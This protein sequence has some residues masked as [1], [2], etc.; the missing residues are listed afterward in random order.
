MYAYDGD[1]LGATYQAG[2]AELKLWAPTATDVTANV[3]G[4][5]DATQFIG[6]VAL[7]KG[8][9]GV[10]SVQLNPGDLG[11]QDFRGYFYQYEV[12]NNGVTKPCWIHMPNPWRN[13]E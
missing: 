9:K 1:D 4:K 12:T 10:W 8:D 7:Q 5:D 6:N 3:Y 11:I 13:S 2:G